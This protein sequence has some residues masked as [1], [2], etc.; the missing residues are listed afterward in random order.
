MS[1]H[2]SSLRKSK[3]PEVSTWEGW[4]PLGGKAHNEVALQSKNH[5]RAESRTIL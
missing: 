3:A 2:L 4:S 1:S 5:L